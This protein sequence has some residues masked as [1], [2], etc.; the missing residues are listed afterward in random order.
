VLNI[1]LYQKKKE[2]NKKKTAITVYRWAQRYTVVDLIFSCPIINK[3]FG[4]AL[5]D[6]NIKNIEILLRQST[7]VKKIFFEYP[8]APL[9]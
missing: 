3:V 1:V 6:N 4:F 5:K 8:D 2:I 9:Y 7:E